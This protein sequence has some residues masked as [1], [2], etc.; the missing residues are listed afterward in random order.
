VSLE[1]H[2]GFYKPLEI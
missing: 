1:G 2:F